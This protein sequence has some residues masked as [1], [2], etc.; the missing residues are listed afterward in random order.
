MSGRWSTLLA[1][2]TPAAAEFLKALDARVNEEG[3]EPEADL[4]EHVLGQMRT[5]PDKAT[6]L[7]DL[8]D[9]FDEGSYVDIGNW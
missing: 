3:F 9:V 2:G 1:D 4:L 5:L 8:V 7:K 6:L